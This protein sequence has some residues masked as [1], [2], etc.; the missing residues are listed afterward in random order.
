[1]IYCSTAPVTNGINDSNIQWE[2]PVYTTTIQPANRR[3]AARVQPRQGRDE[4]VRHLRRAARRA[5]PSPART[6]SIAHL[7]HAEHQLHA[8]HSD[9]MGLPA[10]AG[11]SCWK[12]VV[13][14]NAPNVS[15]IVR[16]YK[17]FYGTYPSPA[18]AR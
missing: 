6:L 13:D 18:N 10:P 12:A 15:Q 14:S 5:T 2:S 17:A 16:I 11:P 3:T 8:P 1:M 4:P 9:K 7:D